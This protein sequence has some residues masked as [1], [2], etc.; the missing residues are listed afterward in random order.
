MKLER[1]LLHITLPTDA[2]VLGFLLT[3]MVSLCPC[4]NFRA[5]TESTWVQVMNR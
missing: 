5:L 1:V 4:W 2:F 3:P